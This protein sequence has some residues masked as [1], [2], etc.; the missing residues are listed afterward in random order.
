MP[1]PVSSFLP[2][3]PSLDRTSPEG[4][5]CGGLDPDAVV[6][7]EEDEQSESDGVCQAQAGQLTGNDN[8]ERGLEEITSISSRHQPAISARASKK[9]RLSTCLEEEDVEIKGEET[10]VS[11]GGP[12]GPQGVNFLVFFQKNEKCF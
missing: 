12:A 9:K 3:N 7:F 5:S 1:S 11:L 2:S 8:N 4:R 6:C 10:S